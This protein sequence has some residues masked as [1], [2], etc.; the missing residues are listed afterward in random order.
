MVAEAAVPP[1]FIWGSKQPVRI[2]NRIAVVL[3]VL[4]A[5][6]QYNDPDSFR[7]VAVYG[8]AAA[9]C[10]L[11]DRHRISTFMLGLVGVLSLI[12]SGWVLAGSVSQTADSVQWAMTPQTESIREGGGLLLVALWMGSLTFSRQRLVGDSPPEKTS[13][14]VRQ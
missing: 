3:F 8:G 1:V 13:G 14:L 4:C 6:V 2:A 5:L 11:W 7:W 9:I 10:I 12:G